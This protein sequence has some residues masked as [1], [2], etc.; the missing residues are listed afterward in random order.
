MKEILGDP[1][2][3]EITYEMAEKIRD[4]IIQLP[5][6]RSR[7]PEWRNLSIEAIL[8]KKPEHTVA[9]KTVNQY[10]IRTS[11]LF[12]WAVNRNIIQVNPFKGIKIKTRQKAS[13][14]RKAFSEKDVKVVFD[15]KKFAPKSKAT[16][17]LLDSSDRCLFWHENGINRSA[18]N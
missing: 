5:P 4:I 6:N 9:Q 7:S 16:F 18:S 1:P 15:P 10:L 2:I 13:E 17:A 8:K 14:Q 11:S 3:D 12:E